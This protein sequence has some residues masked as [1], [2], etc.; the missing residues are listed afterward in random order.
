MKKPILLAPVSDKVMLKCAIDAADAIQQEGGQVN[1]CHV[2]FVYIHMAVMHK[3]SGN[4][5]AAIDQLEEYSNS[6]ATAAYGLGFAYH[7]EGDS[8]KALEAFELAGFPKALFMAA[9]L[10]LVVGMLPGFPFLVFALLAA[11]LTFV[12][13]KMRGEAYVGDTLVA[14]AELMAAIESKQEE[15][16][17]DES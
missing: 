15:T 2:A 5:D 13:F 11:G 17:L 10:S 14:E 9:G 12:G 16:S 6:D 1:A 7:Q 8:D 3:Q 4:Y